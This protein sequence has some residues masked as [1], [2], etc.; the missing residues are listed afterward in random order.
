M[1]ANALIAMLS[2]RL[3][4]G[5]RRAYSTYK[6]KLDQEAEEKRKRD[7]ALRKHSKGGRR[8]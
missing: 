3:V 8:P 7:E 4:D 1:I 6:A 5:A 2:P